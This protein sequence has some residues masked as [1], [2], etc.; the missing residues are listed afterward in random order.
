MVLRRKIKQGK[1]MGSALVGGD[2]RQVVR[3]GLMEEVTSEQ[4]PEGGKG[5]K[6][7]GV[8]GKGAPG[9]DPGKGPWER[10]P[11]KGPWERT[12]PDLLEEEQG[13]HD[14]G[15]E[16]EEVIG[17]VWGGQVM[18]G[19]V[20]RGDHFGIH[21]VPQRPQAVLVKALGLDPSTAQHRPGTQ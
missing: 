19:L 2:I 16:M 3:G 11:R 14:S 18:Q 5:E 10:I 6:H 9:K 8:W 20:G 12:I 21:L 1:K 4:R 17:C 15:G 13:Q 7:A